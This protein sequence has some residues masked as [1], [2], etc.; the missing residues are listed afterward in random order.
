MFGTETTQPLSLSGW[1]G[2]LAPA[3]FV[4]MRA[5]IVLFSEAEAHG[6]GKSGGKHPS[7]PERLSSLKETPNLRN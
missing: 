3:G 6:P 5:C 2:W 7:Q 1:E 4:E